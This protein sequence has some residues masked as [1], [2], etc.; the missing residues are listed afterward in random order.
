MA[1]HQPF[2]KIRERFNGPD[3]PERSRRVETAMREAE[4]EQQAYEQ[5]LAEVR[6]ARAYTQAQIAE[7]LGVPQPQVSRIERQADLYVSTLARY[8]E[9]MGGRL[10]LVGVFNDRRVTL[11]LSDLAPKTED[12]SVSAASTPVPTR[13]GVAVPVPSSELNKG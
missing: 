6:R 10:E 8:L 3:N 5:G 13:F 12:T 1:G 9:A 2:S 4:E 11:A 7:Q